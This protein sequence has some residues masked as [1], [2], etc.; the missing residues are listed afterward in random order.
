MGGDLRQSPQRSYLYLCTYHLTA[1]GGRIFVAP[2]CNAQPCNFWRSDACCPIAPAP[3][4]RQ[5]V[6]PP[7]LFNF[8][9]R[10]KLLIDPAIFLAGC[11]TLPLIPGGLSSSSDRVHLQVTKKLQDC[12]QW[13]WWYFC[14]AGTLSQAHPITFFNFFFRDYY[15]IHSRILVRQFLLVKLGRGFRTTAWLPRE[16]RHPDAAVDGL[17]P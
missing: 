15:T 11:H 17:Q 1:R 6:P 4:Q 9:L 5:S 3:T 2:R 16:R 13:C 14:E 12:S 10:H 7:S 8:L